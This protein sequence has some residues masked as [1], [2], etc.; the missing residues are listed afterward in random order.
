M[1]LSRAPRQGSAV[2]RARRRARNPV[3]QLEAIFG[4]FPQV[5]SSDT[6]EKGGTGLGLAIR[7]KIV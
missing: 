5:D 6:R 7:K 4:Q 2:Q 1:G 3:D